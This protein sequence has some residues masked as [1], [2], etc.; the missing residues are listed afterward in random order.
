MRRLAEPDLEA[1]AHETLVDWVSYA[2]AVAIVEVTGE[3]AIP[4][5]AAEERHHEPFQQRTV[6]V[7]IDEVLYQGL[8]PAAVPER[9]TFTTS[10]WTTKGHDPVGTTGA[11]RFEVG[12]RFLVPLVEWA[13]EGWRPI[14][15]QESLRFADG[16]AEVEGRGATEAAEALD[17]L[18]RAEVRKLLSETDPEPVAAAHPELSSIGRQNAVAE[19]RYGKE[20]KTS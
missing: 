4:L 7:E 5:T 19:A 18:T 12:E 17:G 15:T 8:G 20:K 10:G 13:G 14:S 3:E 16:H 6:T 9:S 11:A 1:M 2:D